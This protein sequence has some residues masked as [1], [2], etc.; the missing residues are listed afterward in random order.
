MLEVLAVFGGGRVAV[1]DALHILVEQSVSA[2]VVLS[3]GKEDG[4]QTWYLVSSVLH[5]PVNS[6]IPTRNGTTAWTAMVA[7]VELRRT[8]R[9]Y[10]GGLWCWESGG[11]NKE[12][13]LVERLWRGTVRYEGDRDDYES[14]EN[15]RQPEA[16]ADDA[17]LEL[18]AVAWLGDAVRISNQ[19]HV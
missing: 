5:T 15:S 13:H 9:S 11:E 14:S 12:P 19:H 10:R 18:T 3:F 16:A 2:R 7:V 4:E 17:S 1:L 6:I 8:R